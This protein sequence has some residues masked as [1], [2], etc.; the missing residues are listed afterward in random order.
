MVFGQMFS[1]I[2]FLNH[3]IETTLA[4]GI[5]RTLSHPRN[6]LEYFIFCKWPVWNGLRMELDLGLQN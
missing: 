4:W 5:P 6:S 1:S 2:D 3:L